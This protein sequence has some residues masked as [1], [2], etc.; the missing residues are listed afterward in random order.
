MFYPELFYALTVEINIGSIK[1]D[2]HVFLYIF[3]IILLTQEYSHL[4]G[5]AG[6]KIFRF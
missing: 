1:D 2:I 6:I 3:L 5:N 4:G